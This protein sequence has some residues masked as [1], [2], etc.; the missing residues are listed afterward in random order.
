MTPERK[1]RVGMD[2]LLVAAGMHVCDVAQANIHPAT[3]VAIRELSFA[4]GF[5]FVDY[6]LY[7]DGKA[8]GVVEAN[9]KRNERATIASLLNSE[10]FNA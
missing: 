5:G 9:H 10:S 8:C 6:L 1:A 2:V 7:V 3:G 4:S